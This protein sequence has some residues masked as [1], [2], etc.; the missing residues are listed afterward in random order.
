MDERP[1]SLDGAMSM[2]GNAAGRVALGGAATAGV[3]HMAHRFIVGRAPREAAARRCAHLWK[4]GVACS[5]D[6]LGEATVTQD[7]A[8]RYAERCV[9]ALD[10]LAEGDAAWPSRAALEADSRG[11]LP[12]ANLSVKVSALTPL[13]RPE[14]PEI[15]REDA[16]AAAAPAAACRRTS[17]VPTCTWT[18]SRVDT[19][20]ATLD[21]VFELLTEDE[22]ARR[23]LGGRG[24]AG[25]P[26]RVAGAARAGPEWA[27]GD[28]AADR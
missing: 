15:G 11:P 9:E 12:R 26:A 20:E 8:D 4:D 1:P 27:R 22:F 21:L 2:A 3:R 7:E 6:L 25:L 13:L 14:A 18:W 24:A 19:L 28:R 17:S 10:E 5:L 16:A 23:A